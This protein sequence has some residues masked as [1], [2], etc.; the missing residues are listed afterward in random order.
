MINQQPVEKT[1]SQPT[2]MERAVLFLKEVQSEV[3]R[4]TWP[5]GNE[6]KAATTVVI[7]V[8]IFLAVIIW[9]VDKIISLS[10]NVLFKL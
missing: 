1:I 10:V 4:V 8:C 6:V 9:A 3:K 7:V 2:L 5:K